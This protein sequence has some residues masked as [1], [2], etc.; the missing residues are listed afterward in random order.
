MC[1]TEPLSPSNY[2][3]IVAIVTALV[4]QNDI[5]ITF[6]YVLN[7]TP[8]NK[9]ITANLTAGTNTIYAFDP[10]VTYPPDTTLVLHSVEITR[11]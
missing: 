1:P 4:A 9:T 2:V 7:D 3:N 10:S 5:D 11:S 6:K 8:I